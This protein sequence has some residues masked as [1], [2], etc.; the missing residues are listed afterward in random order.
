[1]LR[2][3][4]QSSRTFEAAPGL[5][6]LLLSNAAGQVNAAT[7]APSVLVIGRH[8]AGDDTF[9]SQ[10]R[11]RDLIGFGDQAN[12]CDQRARVPPQQARCIARQRAQALPVG[13][14]L[15]R[16]SSLA[17]AQFCDGATVP[18]GH[19]QLALPEGAFGVRLPTSASSESL[20]HL[21]L[22]VAPFTRAQ[23]SDLR[24]VGEPT[25]W[26]VAFNDI[27]GVSAGRP[28]LA[29]SA[30]V[31][32]CED[33][34]P[35]PRTN[36]IRSLATARASAPSPRRSSLRAIAKPDIAAGTRHA[37]SPWRPPARPRMAVVRPLRS[38]G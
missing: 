29:Y 20:E 19:Y 22:E 27:P 11:A 8:D 7:D 5:D 17:E 18:L 35:V 32:H 12:C 37:C 21:V 26:T 6:A 3:A 10:R 14:E 16:G 15:E 30:R 13:N 25:L 36:G 31:R 4:R 33:E 2:F 1:M 38:P 24:Q 23:N 34:R 9:S 28:C